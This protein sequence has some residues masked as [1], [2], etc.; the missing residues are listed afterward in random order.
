[1]NHLLE[2]CHCGHD[3]ASHY[4]SHDSYPP[5]LGMC[6][7]RGCECARFVDWNEPK[8][9]KVVTRGERPEHAGWCQCYRCKQFDAPG[10]GDAVPLFV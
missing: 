9:P 10:V 8:P 6:L 4:R 5:E 3:K 7:C 1:M 2:N